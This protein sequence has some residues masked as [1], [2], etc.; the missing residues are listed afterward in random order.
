MSRSFVKNGQ[1]AYAGVLVAAGSSIDDD[2][3][4]FDMQGFKNAVFF[5]TIT[6]SAATGVATLTVDTNTTN[7][8]GGTA[9]TGASD[10]AT[11]AVN[12][13]LNGKFLCVEVENVLERYVYA[14]RASA[15]ANIAYGEIFCY[16]HNGVGR[17]QKVP[18]SAHST[19]AGTPDVQVDA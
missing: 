9:V 6:D 1:L 2:S 5:T 15:T 7:A 10:S 3:S 8:T 11:C 17:G 4:V 19:A 14:N 16:L 18:L 12:D 13:D